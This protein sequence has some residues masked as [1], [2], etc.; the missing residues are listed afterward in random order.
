MTK[1][2]ATTALA[3]FVY[4]KNFVLDKKSYYDNLHCDSCSTI[5]NI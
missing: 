2:A 4:S 5:T 3:L 1:N